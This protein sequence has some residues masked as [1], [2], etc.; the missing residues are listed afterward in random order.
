MHYLLPVLDE[1]SALSHFFV[2]YIIKCIFL[3]LFHAP[4]GIALRAVGVVAFEHSVATIGQTLAI[5]IV[6]WNGAPVAALGIVV[7]VSVFDALVYVYVLVDQT[8][9]IV[10]N[11]TMAF[12]REPKGGACLP[13]LGVE[14]PTI[15]PY[16]FD[17]EM[18]WI[19]L[20]V[21][22]GIRE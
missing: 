15:I 3:F 22:R 12:S 13:A 18:R 1:D 8:G 21:T 10:L 14:V 16:A 5:L 6:K 2:T 20:G 17:I 11:I 7:K 19:L 9:I 4:D